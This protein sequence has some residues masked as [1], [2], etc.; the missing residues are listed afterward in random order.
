MNTQGIL[1]P[2][3]LKNQVDTDSD[4]DPNADGIT[5]DYFWVLFFRQKAE[6]FWMSSL[7]SSGQDF[8]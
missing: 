3:N 6:K 2:F 1:N 8:R 7:P 5:P 4:T